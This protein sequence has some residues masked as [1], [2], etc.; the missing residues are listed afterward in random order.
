[1]FLLA[2]SLLSGCS[3]FQRQIETRTEYVEVP[4][5]LYPNCPEVAFEGGTLG[6]LT[7]WSVTSLYPTY[8]LCRSDVQI[9]IDYLESRD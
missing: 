2:M 1:V 8:Q 7:D 9:L 6:E 5:S 3:L 4:K